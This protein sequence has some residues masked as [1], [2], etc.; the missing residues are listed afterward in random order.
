MTLD[1]RFCPERCGH[2]LTRHTETGCHAQYS[3]AA[4]HVYRCPC[5]F[6]RQRP[7]EE[8]ERERKRTERYMKRLTQEGGRR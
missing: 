1:G 3:A 6:E 5:R 4:G 7:P 8:I 2:L